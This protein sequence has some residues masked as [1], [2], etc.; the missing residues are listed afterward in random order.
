LADFAASTELGEFLGFPADAGTRGTLMLGLASAAIR[1]ACEGMTLD[2]FTGR[3]E[4]FGPTDIDTLF[5][6]ERPVTAL[7]SVVEDGTTLT[8]FVWTRW[9]TIRKI[10]EAAWDIGNTVVTYDS[11]FASTSDEAVTLKTICLEVAALA[12]T[13]E[14]NNG[15]EQ[16]G[17]GVEAVGWA[18]R[19][20]LT[21]RH[22]AL[23]RD[24]G[25]VPV[26]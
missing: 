25:P 21:D 12:F 6:S 22:L 10:S 13:N 16:F 14:P 7:T 5:L 8:E 23:L 3:V 17:G 2:A 18:P 20:V 9:G 15:P 1:R 4:T 26:G 24:F 11:G 19:I